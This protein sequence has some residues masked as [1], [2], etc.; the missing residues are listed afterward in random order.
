MNTYTYICIHIHNHIHICVYYI[1]IYVIFDKHCIHLPLT[2][3]LRQVI[4]HHGL[5]WALCFL[6]DYPNT[7]ETKWKE[8]GKRNELKSKQSKLIVYPLIDSQEVIPI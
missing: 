4:S 6:D 3:S 8:H 5:A 7:G 1:Y 2:L